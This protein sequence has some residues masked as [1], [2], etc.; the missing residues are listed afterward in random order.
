MAKFDQEW[1][2]YVGISKTTNT[3]GMNP[4][5][6][7]FLPEM[8]PNAD[9]CLPHDVERIGGTSCPFGCTCGQYDFFTTRVIKAVFLGDN[10]HM[11]PC[12]HEGERVRCLCYGGTEQYYWLPMGRDPSL[13]RHERI[14]WFAMAQPQAV[15]SPPSYIDYMD[16]NSS[17]S[18][19]R[20]I[21][22]GAGKTPTVP[23]SSWTRRTST[24]SVR[25]RV[26]STL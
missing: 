19:G 26:P 1:A 2:E 9:G 21:T 15:I 13:R 22:S 5:L 10:N 23:T 7:V 4:M 8:L 14:R 12:I 3:D 6:D 18:C 25:T 20:A 24:C 11:V 16:T 17:L